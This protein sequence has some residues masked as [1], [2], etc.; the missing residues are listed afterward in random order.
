MLRVT[1]AP[2]PLPEFHD[3]LLLVTV[4]GD[5]AFRT[6]L[7]QAG[8]TAARGAGLSQVFTAGLEF[9]AALAPSVLTDVAAPMMEVLPAAHRRTMDV[10]ANFVEAG[11][12]LDIA[13]ILPGRDEIIRAVGSGPR[14]ASVALAASLGPLPSK[15][16]GG[17]ALDGTSVM[18]VRN[19]AARERVARA[20]ADRYGV[21]A[22]RVPR[23]YLYARGARTGKVAGSPATVAA[24]P[25]STGA[26]W[27]L[28]KTRTSEARRAAKFIEPTR[29]KL[30]ILDTGIDDEHPLLQKRVHRYVPSYSDLSVVSGPK[31]IV[32]HGT[33]VAGTVVAALDKATGV[34]GMCECELWALKIFGDQTEYFPQLGYFAYAVDPRMYLR[35]LTMC[36]DEGIQVA[37]LSIGGPGQTSPQEAQLFNQMIGAG[38][39]VVAAMGNERELNSPISYPAA[40][41]GVIAVGATDPGDR[42][43]S[44]SNRGPHISISAP[45]K[46]IWSTMPTYGGQYGF[47]PDNS[48]PHRKEGKP[49]KRETLF[50]Q[51]D[52][53]SM[54]SPQVAAAAAMYLARNPGTAPVDVRTALTDKAKKVDGMGGASFHQDYGFGRLDVAALLP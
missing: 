33:H 42:V 9:A 53:T 15:D 37:N 16:P 20:L 1:A 38:C 27:H 29:I 6:G 54:A 31:D 21:T 19:E 12:V 11:D 48:S 18:R 45:G 17:A 46:G 28:E 44:F 14:L 10:L 51:E 8:L 23:R 30:A 26:A 39:V 22:S 40:H 50:G 35:A 49:I 2:E 5:E 41:P 52:G 7:V 34:S 13:P 3:D 47:Y 43:A 32:G 36:I 4:T 25:P 24:V